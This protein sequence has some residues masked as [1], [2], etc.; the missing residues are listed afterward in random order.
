MENLELYGGNE[1]SGRLETDLES[2]YFRII[3]VKIN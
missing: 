2:G 1:G 3:W